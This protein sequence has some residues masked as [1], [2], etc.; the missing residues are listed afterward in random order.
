[1]KVQVAEH[2]PLVAILRGI[3][4]AEAV[5]YVERLVELGYYF[6]E[7][8][9]NSPNA[10]QTISLLHQHFASRCMIGAGTVT[11][12]TALQQVLE[13]GVRLVVTPNMNPEVIELA[14]QHQCLLFVGV[15]TPTE[16]FIAIEKGAK[17]LKIYPAEVVG[18][19]GLKAMKAVLPKDIQCFPVGGVQPNAKQMQQY[20]NAG[21]AGFGIGSALYTTGISIEE[22]TRRAQ[23]FKQAY[24]AA[25]C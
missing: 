25:I 23:M 6:I 14:V 4:T 8:P 5:A 1:M 22:L 18:V 20:L 24:L 15:M 3:Q 12:V 21:A 9:L 10:L 11:N 7:V 17:Q 19:M 13:T 2:L 16:A